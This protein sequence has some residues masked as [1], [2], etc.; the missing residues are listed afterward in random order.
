MALS[1]TVNRAI[2]KGDLRELGLETGIEQ[3]GRAADCPVPGRRSSARMT[4]ENKWRLIQRIPAVKPPAAFMETSPGKNPALIGLRWC[5]ASRHYSASPAQISLT[6]CSQTGV[7]MWVT[8][9]A[10][11]QKGPWCIFGAGELPCSVRARTTVPVW[12]LCSGHKSRINQVQVF[13]TNLFDV[14]Q[15]GDVLRARRHF[16]SRGYL[17]KGD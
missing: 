8:A 16:A 13:S 5:S 1:Q 17:E 15:R 7:F 2:D 10:R 4:C 9:L 11:S 6:A 12:I 14:A 3:A